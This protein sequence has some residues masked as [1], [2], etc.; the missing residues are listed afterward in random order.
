MVNK[1][2]YKLRG[3]K[4]QKEQCVPRQQCKLL[5]RCDFR[6]KL[7]FIDKHFSFKNRMLCSQSFHWCRRIA[8]QES[9]SHSHLQI[10]THSIYYRLLMVGQMLPIQND[11]NLYYAYSSKYLK[12]RQYQSHLD[13]HE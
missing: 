9:D 4:K 5:R 12:Q 2:F 11:I 6:M 3:F 8:T 10:Y 13:S 1:Y 7:Y